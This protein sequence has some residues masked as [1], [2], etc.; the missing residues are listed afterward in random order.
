MKKK[1]LTCLFLLVTA[2]LLYPQE[3]KI[4]LAVSTILYNRNEIKPGDAEKVN[5]YFLKSIETNKQVVLFNV[6]QLDKI[7]SNLGIRNKE[8]N[9]ITKDIAIKIQSTSTVNYIVLPIINTVD[10]ELYFGVKLI[11]IAD[12][13]S[14][15]LPPIRIEDALKASGTLQKVVYDYSK[16]LL[17]KVLSLPEFIN[18]ASKNSGSSFSLFRLNYDHSY[19]SANVAYTLPFYYTYYNLKPA[20][21]FNV[22]NEFYGSEEN[23]FSFPL[24]LEMFF[25]QHEVIAQTATSILMGLGAGGGV[26]YHLS[27]PLSFHLKGVVG[28]SATLLLYDRPVLDL[29]NPP[30][31]KKYDFNPTAYLSASLEARYLLNDLIGISL[32]GSGLLMMYD[33]RSSVTEVQ[34]GASVGIRL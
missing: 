23:T 19:L 11:N 32:K 18:M 10:R 25:I 3:E 5:D 17:R 14:E 31:T 2:F 33:M 34:I 4:I 9:K 24:V 6:D 20:I 26:G 27:F 13:E 28:F 16:F 1:L 15:N 22:N 7:L 12:G 30:Y 29:K 21:F 8:Y